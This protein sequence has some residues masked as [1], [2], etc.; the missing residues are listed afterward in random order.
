M[1]RRNCRLGAS[2][3]SMLGISVLFTLVSMSVRGEGPQRIATEK[4]VT[5]PPVSQDGFVIVDGRLLDPPYKLEYDSQ[6]LTVNGVRAM[7]AKASEK[8]ITVPPRAAAQHQVISD[9]YALF[10]MSVT[11]DGLR[12]ARQRAFAYMKGQPL[13]EEAALLDDGQTLRIKFAG[14]KWEE[15][16]DLSPPRPPSVLPAQP[17]QDYLESLAKSIQHWLE[18]GCLVVLGEGVVMASSPGEGASLVRE[19]RRIIAGESS[20]DK[21][22]SAIREI[23]SDSK[24]SRAIAEQLQPE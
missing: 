4:P 17:Q 24:L 1:N 6:V 14:E 20:I 8:T 21:R 18:N 22:V 16:L 13:I 9:M 10:R 5:K 3:F 7:Q 23:I 2:L 12:V 15:W 19:L 11:E